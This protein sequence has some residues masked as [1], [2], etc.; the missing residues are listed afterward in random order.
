MNAALQRISAQ[1]NAAIGNF[2]PVTTILLA[3]LVLGESLT[4]TDAAGAALV[5]AGIG[6]FTLG[7]LAAG[8]RQYCLTK[9]NAP[10]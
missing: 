9:Q 6:W 5:L 4:P 1:A 7:R 3:V 2:S 10:S 8:S